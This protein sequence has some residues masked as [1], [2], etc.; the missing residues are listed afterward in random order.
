ME[1]DVWYKGLQMEFSEWAGVQH[2]LLF[3]Q[4]WYV[5]RHKLTQMGSASDVTQCIYLKGP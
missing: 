5:E 3:N 4:T 1:V 2:N